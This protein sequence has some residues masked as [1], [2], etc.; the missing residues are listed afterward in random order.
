VI[1]IAHLTPNAARCNVKNCRWV[2]TV[3]VCLGITAPG[4]GWAEPA[5]ADWVNDPYAPHVTRGSTVRLGSAVGFLYGER[6]DVFAIGVTAAVGQRF[7]RI[8]LE[9]ELDVLTLQVR[10]PSSQR[11]GDHERLGVVARLDVVRLGPRWV[12]P[13]SL[14][15]LYVEGGA[16]IAWNHWY[17]PAYN[18]P[19]RVVPDDTR[20][21]EGQAGFGFSIDHR[22]QKPLGFPRRVGWFLGWR[23]AL[24]PHDSDPATVCRGAICRLAPAMP[25]PRYTEGSMLFQSSLSATW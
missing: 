9:A 23:L 18:E 17:R 8:A 19:M 25:E 21:V 1:C 24:A 22:L 10:G 20:R 11:L 7:G 14:L 13:N 5:Q 4:I 2:A 12:G 16:A 15:A 6:Q 3:L